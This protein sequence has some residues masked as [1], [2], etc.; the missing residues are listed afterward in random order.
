MVELVIVYKNGVVSK[1]IWLEE[2]E[3]DETFKWFESNGTGKLIVITKN[4]PNLRISIEKSE[5]ASL[6]TK[7]IKEE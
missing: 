4:N 7:P 5:I 6:Q 1:D 3:I 2:Y